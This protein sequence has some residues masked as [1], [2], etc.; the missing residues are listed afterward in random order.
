[1]DRLLAETPDLAEDQFGLQC[2]LFDLGAVE[3][4][5]SA[6]PSLATRAFGPRRPLVHLAFS[7][8]L[9]AYPELEN[10]MLA[11]V[12]LLIANGADVNDGYPVYPGSDQ[13]LSALH[14]AIGHADNMVLGEWLLENGADPDDGESLYHA[15]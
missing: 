5:L 4:V 8:H 11:I 7:K 13:M 1:M 2:A 9:K 3:A 14:G 12:E 15:T 6:D 10:D